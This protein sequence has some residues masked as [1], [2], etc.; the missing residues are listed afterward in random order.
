MAKAKKRRRR[1]EAGTSTSEDRSTTIFPRRKPP[2]KSR[3]KIF[4]PHFHLILN[5]TS[6]ITHLS[7]GL[8]IHD[9]R[10]VHA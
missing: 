6:S 1:T 3:T 2:L 4:C 9:Y 5:L 8:I 10:N 7:T